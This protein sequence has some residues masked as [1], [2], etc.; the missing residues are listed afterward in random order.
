MWRS[1]LPT[2]LM[3]RQEQGWIILRGLFTAEPPGWRLNDSRVGYRMN[4]LVDR[5]TRF[6]STP[7]ILKEGRKKSILNYY[8]ENCN[9]IL[10]V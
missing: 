2:E 3:S 9:V 8:A 4:L 10:V 7:S 5:I 6:Y 1:A